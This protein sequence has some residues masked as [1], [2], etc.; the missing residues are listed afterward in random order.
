MSKL[1]KLIDEITEFGINPKVELTDKND[2]LKKLLVGIYSEFLNA[3]FEFDEA[4]YEKE[5]E[6]D[7]KEILKNVKSNFQNFG[8]YS[9]VLDSNKMEPNI[10]IGIGDELDD[11][12]DIIKDLLA[13][14][15]RMENTSLNDAL[16][17]FEFSMRTHSEQHL[18]DLLK[19]LK[20]RSE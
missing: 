4:D 3:E 11:L 5:P 18:V 15:W 8:W 20:E 2:V 14:K 1:K 17:N 7:Y 13:V 10:E 6:F 19:R 12:T 16:W 9:S